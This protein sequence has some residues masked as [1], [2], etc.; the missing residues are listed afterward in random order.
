MPEQLLARVETCYRQAEAFFGKR[1][2]RPVVSLK[3]RGQKAGVA[4]LDEN[5]LR[6][7]TQLYLENK[8]HFLHQTVA[9]E[10]AHLVAH[11]LFGPRIRP[12][13][14][15]WQQIMRGVFD[16]TPARC[17]QYQVARR[18]SRRYI[19]RCECPDRDFAFSARRHALV[20][21]GHRY[22][23]KQCNAPLVHNGQQRFE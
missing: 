18:K 2:L 11:Q 7:N 1:F 23:C 12:H 16:L 9:H 19:Y 20:A 4:Y 5:R 14:K 21:K 3:L 15:E 6:F 17:H 10:V 22:R 8:E 13:G